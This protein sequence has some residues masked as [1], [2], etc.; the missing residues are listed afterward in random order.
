MKC[1]E[2]RKKKEK[3]YCKVCGFPKVPPEIF[4]LRPKLEMLKNTLEN[5]VAKTLQY[6]LDS[7][8]L[9]Q[10]T[11]EDRHFKNVRLQIKDFKAIQE[12]KL[13]TLYSK[14]LEK[15]SNAKKLAAL[16]SKLSQEIM[17]NH[18]N[19]KKTQ[20]KLNKL[21]EK[22]SKMRAKKLKYYNSILEMNTIY[23]HW[24]IYKE[25]RFE[26]EGD[27][28]PIEEEDISD[29]CIDSDNE[30]KFEKITFAKNFSSLNEIYGGIMTFALNQLAKIVYY[31]ANLYGIL[32]PLVMILQMDNVKIGNYMQNKEFFLMR[33]IAMRKNFTN[34]EKFLI[35]LLMN[36]KFLMKSFNFEVE[37]QEFIN[38]KAFLDKFLQ[39][40]SGNIRKSKEIDK[41]SNFFHL[42]KIIKVKYMVNEEKIHIPQT[43]IFKLED[44]MVV[45]LKSPRNISGKTRKSWNSPDVSNLSIPSEEPMSNDSFEILDN[46]DEISN[47]EET[48]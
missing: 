11:L 8:E 18:E 9:K 13:K 16:K 38:W 32:T 22:L 20:D 48:D 2:C 25:L 34:S 39:N 10:R 28:S 7:Q 12:E 43:P 41:K 33:N 4:K 29:A 15:L 46:L 6:Y 17:K 19:L 35:L 30:E 3:L 40:R 21:K 1:S 45:I 44:S 14:K 24:T 47:L 37:D 26:K 23:P 42:F 31:F 36:M 5:K 27:F